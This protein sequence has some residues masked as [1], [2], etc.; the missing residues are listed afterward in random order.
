MYW[1][2][3]IKAKNQ[4]KKPK[5]ASGVELLD[6]ETTRF[7]SDGLPDVRPG[8]TGARAPVFPHNQC[9]ITGFTN[10]LFPRKFIHCTMLPHSLLSFLLQYCLQKVR[11]LI[12]KLQTRCNRLFHN[13]LI[14][15]KQPL[16]HV[17]II[18]IYAF[19]V[20]GSL[21]IDVLLVL[22]YSSHRC[23]NIFKSG[24]AKIK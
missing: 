16:L 6:F 23:S 17:N 8:S 24:G 12:K 7:L 20:V 2:N 1:Y 18:M 9:M 13:V 15:Y 14:H 22:Y 3:L 21:S 19:T 11:N 10:L 5:E 4:F